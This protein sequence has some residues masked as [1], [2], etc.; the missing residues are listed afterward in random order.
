[1]A[2]LAIRCVIRE[3][4]PVVTSRR[5]NGLQFRIERLKRSGL[6]GLPIF[7]VES[8]MDMWEAHKAQ[9]LTPKP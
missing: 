5:I 7:N 2:L 3:Y 8:F 9:S 4:G 1:M 6:S